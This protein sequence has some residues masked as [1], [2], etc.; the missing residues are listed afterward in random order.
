MSATMPP[1]APCV[2]RNGAI[3]PYRH[4]PYSHNKENHRVGLSRLQKFAIGRPPH[5]IFSKYLALGVHKAS[6][7]GII[8]SPS[9]S[10]HLPPYPRTPTPI[11]L[12]TSSWPPLT[13]FPTPALNFRYALTC[14]MSARWPAIASLPPKPACLTSSCHVSAHPSDRARSPKSR[15]TTRSAMS[16]S[17]QKPPVSPLLSHLD[18][19]SAG[20]SPMLICC[21]DNA[22]SALNFVINIVI[23]T[24]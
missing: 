24:P 23:T 7:P 5:V 1:L 17:A 2:R 12:P 9:S 18:F 15:T 3:G 11:H 6:T 14:P 19:H 22:S 13:I 20:P 21:A 10:T 8:S 16:A 4:V